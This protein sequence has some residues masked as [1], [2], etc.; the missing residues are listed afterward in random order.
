MLECL[1]EIVWQ[2]FV[3][4]AIDFIFYRFKFFVFGILGLLLTIW[5][6]GYFL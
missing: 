1:L 3:E 2:V 6:S 4:V 5:L